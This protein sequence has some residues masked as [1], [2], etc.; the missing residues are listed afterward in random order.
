MAK[1]NIL[2]HASDRQIKD[3]KGEISHL[4][5]MLKADRAS[6][7]P[8][9]ADEGEF[10]GEINKKKKLIKEHSPKMFKGEKANKALRLARKIEKVLQEHMPR[11]RDHEMKQPTGYSK[12]FERTVEQEMAYMTNPKLKELQLA[13]KNIMRRLDPQDPTVTNIE[14]L[15]K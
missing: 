11:K 5:N 7:N 8:K 12:D 9:I 4:E 3:W 14:R 15:R 10:R 2:V 13:Y 6:G 1:K